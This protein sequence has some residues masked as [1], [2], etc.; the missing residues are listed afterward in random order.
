MLSAKTS[1]VT[2]DPNML[3]FKSL[4]SFSRLANEKMAGTELAKKMQILV[5]SLE[6]LANPDY[7]AQHEIVNALAKKTFLEIIAEIK[8]EENYT[9]LKNFCL[10]MGSN[11][12][13]SIM[14]KRPLSFMDQMRPKSAA[15][16]VQLFE[17][18]KKAVLAV[19]TARQSTFA[20]EAADQ[21][22]EIE[23]LSKQDSV[24]YQTPAE[25]KTST[26]AAIATA[27]RFALETKQQ[28][29]LNDAEEKLLAEMAGFFELVFVRQLEGAP[30]DTFLPNLKK[31]FNSLIESF[32]EDKRGH[33]VSE[34]EG[35]MRLKQFARVVSQ[36]KDWLLDYADVN[37]VPG[38]NKQPAD[39]KDVFIVEDPQTVKIKEAV[40]KAAAFIKHVAELNEKN[41]ENGYRV[42]RQVMVKA[43][44]IKEECSRADLAALKSLFTIEANKIAAL[45]PMTLKINL[46]RRGTDIAEA[47]K[48]GR[49]H[50]DG[51][52]AEFLGATRVIENG[53]RHAPTVNTSDP[54]EYLRIGKFPGVKS[55]IKSIY[56]DMFEGI[57]QGK[58]PTERPYVNENKEGMVHMTA[59]DPLVAEQKE[60]EYT[61]AQQM[62]AIMFSVNYLR[63]QHIE[64]SK[65]FILSPTAQQLEELN[66]Q[67]ATTVLAMGFANKVF[68]YAVTKAACDQFNVPYASISAEFVELVRA[69]AVARAAAEAIV[70][71]ARQQQPRR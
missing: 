57:K 60:G 26:S 32:A 5:A 48:K 44:H 16:L 50:G 21:T 10:Y 15:E 58:L 67:F 43:C 19:Y 52:G 31:Q 36:N 66:T 42:L 8:K 54:D 71:A 46:E 69:E 70:N 49:P 55:K 29:Q 30:G 56:H 47:F 61:D 3:M 62:F 12:A 17:A 45:I 41:I 25:I 33:A 6:R 37:K 1:T 68:N 13:L 64:K 24:A 2:A 34:A 63:R 35:V 53:M 38:K 23:L 65:S 9:L 4:A 39:E 28:D 11:K 27:M 14:L 20:V 18:F 40:A 22:R 7:A 51:W 59:I